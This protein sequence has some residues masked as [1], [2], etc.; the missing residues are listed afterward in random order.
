MA[1]ARSELLN[2]AL[3]YGVGSEDRL[4][5]VFASVLAVNGAFAAALMT[6]VGLPAGDNFEVLTQWRLASGRRPD[7]VVRSVRNGYRVSE[8]WSE[9]KTVSGFSDL[10]R[11]DYSQ[12]LAREPV[13][14]GALLTITP[15]AVDS[16]SEHWQHRSWQAVGEL[17]YATGFAWGD[18][19]W[20]NKALDG[21]VPSKW[22]LLHEFLWYLERE[23]YAVTQPLTSEDML[24]MS[25]MSR[26]L[27]GV[28]ALIRRT[29]VLVDSAVGDDAFYDDDN[30]TTWYFSVEALPGMNWL[31]RF[32]GFETWSETAVS[33]EGEWSPRGAGV[34]AVG[35]GYTL[36]A[37]L[38]SALSTNRELTERLA[39]AGY[40]LVLWRN[41]VRI[42]RTEPLASFLDAGPRLDDQAKALAAWVS[43]TY[44]DLGA[45]DPGELE[46]PEPRARRKR[47]RA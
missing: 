44:A 8:L 36:D 41:Y 15:D 21:D 4:T 25:R 3:S 28:E 26:T 31:M 5:E 19:D 27:D 24:V 46:L 39:D 2:A 9:H 6:D 32:A 1:E 40:E 38:Y 30:M 23:G 35:S 33:C 12:A 11:E 37:Q 34:P 16:S 29:A 43:T 42:W 10:Q 22:R 18:A 7:M 13:E 14:V 17:A 20:R 47:P 45:L